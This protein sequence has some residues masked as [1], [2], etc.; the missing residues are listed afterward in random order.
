LPFFD[1]YFGRINNFMQFYVYIYID[2]KSDEPVYV[3]KGHG[4]RAF[5]HKRK[6]THL[7]NLIR[8]RI[9]DGYSLEP[10][11]IN[12]PSENAA[13]AQEI[14]WI[15]IYGRKDIGTGSLIN[16]TN[17]GEGPSGQ[18]DRRTPEK[19]A[20]DY[21]NRIDQS[22][23]NNPYYGK[24]HSD[25][26]KEKISSAKKGVKIHSDEF[27]L[28]QSKRQ[29]GQKRSQETCDKIGIRHLGKI[30]TEET[31]KKQSAAA[32]GRKMSEETKE[33]MRQAQLKRWAFAKEEVL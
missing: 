31:K 32:R 33:K 22:G 27:K 21:A 3:G 25:E 1:D 23:E 17:G 13:F 15:N 9:A 16:L 12:C 19:K 2:P 20:F 5:D 30:V 14:F 24:K 26:I 11:I 7:G 18:I 28:A 29:T 4:T 8:K 10:Q 6:K